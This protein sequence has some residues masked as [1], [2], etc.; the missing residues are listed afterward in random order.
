MRYLALIIVIIFASSCK[1]DYV[2]IEDKIEGSWILSD[3]KYTDNTGKVV[4]ESPSN[5]QITFLGT[6]TR[7]GII[8]APSNEFTFEYNFGPDKC[9]LDFSNKKA[10]PLEIIGKVQVYSYELL[11][12]NKLIFSIDKEYDYTTNQVLRNVTYTFRRM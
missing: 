1:P 8:K 10:L 12:R 2:K 6:T 5:V 11:D 7:K 3:F 9:N 4:S